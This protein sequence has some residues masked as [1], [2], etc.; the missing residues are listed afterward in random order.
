MGYEVKLF[1]VERFPDDG[2]CSVVAE[3]DLCKP[4]RI[5]AVV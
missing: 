5:V 4:G 1:A 3:I 2:Y